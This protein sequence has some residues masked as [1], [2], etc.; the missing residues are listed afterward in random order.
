MPNL[1]RYSRVAALIAVF[2]LSLAASPIVWVCGDGKPC[3]YDCHHGLV[4]SAPRPKTSDPTPHHT[5]CPLADAADRDGPSVASGMSCRASAVARVSVVPSAGEVI[6][7]AAALHSSVSEFALP[8]PSFPI[9]PCDD[10]GP[11]GRDPDGPSSPR[12]P[13]ISL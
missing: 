11:P 6:V 2:V 13:P 4:T 12:A 5:C 7:S 10:A 8:A 9:V 3:D 1:K